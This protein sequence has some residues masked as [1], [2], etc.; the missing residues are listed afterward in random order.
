MNTLEEKCALLAQTPQ[1]RWYDLR[2]KPMA[3]MLI[4]MTSDGIISPKELNSPMFALM[5]MNIHVFKY[6]GEFY[7]LFVEQ[8][9]TVTE[10]FHLERTNSLISHMISSHI[11][12]SSDDDKHQE[13][14]VPTLSLT[15]GVTSNSEF[16]SKLNSMF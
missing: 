4:N 7:F 12:L 5:N 11:V 15:M 16:I 10:C 6:D 9:G 3:L 2:F 13:T 14:Y 1:S 8:K